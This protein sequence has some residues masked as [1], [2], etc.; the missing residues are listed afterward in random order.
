MK[1]AEWREHLLFPEEVY[2][3]G[4]KREEKLS[5]ISV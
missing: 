3:P 1:S 4:S 5:P 2:D